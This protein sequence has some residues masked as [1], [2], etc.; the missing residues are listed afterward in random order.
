MASAYSILH[1]YDQPVYS[2]D[3]N[4]I[5]TA[6]SYKQQKFDQNVAKLQNAADQFAI[7]KVKRGVDQ[8]YINNRLNEVVRTTN[9]AMKGMDLSDDNFYTSLAANVGQVLDDNVKT[10]VLSTRQIQAEDAAM[11]A[12][13]K[14][15]KDGKYSQ[16]NHQYAIA[17]SDRA[18]YLTSDK[19][20]DGY[21]GGFNYIEYRDLSK[22]V[23][24]NL[25]KLA[26]G[27]KESFL[28]FV[29]QGSFRAMETYDKVDQ[30]KIKEAMSIVFDQKDMAQ[31]DVD[32]WATYGNVPLDVLKSEYE[33]YVRPKVDK[34]EEDLN[35]LQIR[36]KQDISPDEKAEIRKEIEDRQTYL[37]EVR[38]NNDFDSLLQANGRE[39]IEQRL[40]KGQF[41]E[42]IANT[43][44]Y[45]ERFVKRELDEV[46]AKNVELTEKQRQFDL[47][48]ELK[49][50]RLEFD[51]EQ[52]KLKAKKGTQQSG[53]VDDVD[54]GRSIVDYTGVFTEDEKENPIKI[55]E[56]QMEA[57]EKD[58]KALIRER[59]NGKNLTNKQFAEFSQLLDLAKVQ[60]GDTYTITLS[61]GTSL[62]FDPNKDYDRLSK[63]YKGFVE[64][65]PERKAYYEQTKNV[66]AR[67]QNDLVKLVR[68]KNSEVYN[69]I[70]TFY[71]KV[72]GDKKNG[73][74]LQ[75]VNGSGY[76]SYL[77]Q[78]EAKGEKLSE[79]DKMTLEAYTSLNLAT[80]DESAGD[81]AD[82]NRKALLA[83][84]RDR[85]L[86]GVDT[87]GLLPTLN[88][89]SPS[90]KFA[91]EVSYDFKSKSALDLY[92]KIL[93]SNGKSVVGSVYPKIPKG[94]V[95]QLI[96]KVDAF[97]DLQSKRNLTK[98]ELL[99]FKSTLQ[100]LRSTA[101]P[102][103]KVSANDLGDL[104]RIDSRFK[105][106]KGKI[107]SFGDY[108]GRLDS[109]WGTANSELEKVL[110]PSMD[111][112]RVGTISY[113]ED[114]PSYEGLRDFVATSSP[115]VNKNFSKPIF[116][117]RHPTDDTKVQIGITAKGGTGI[118]FKDFDRALVEQAVP[119]AKLASSEV[120]PYD[121]SKG[122]YAR[123]LNLG[124]NNLSNVE[125]QVAK[126]NKQLPFSTYSPDILLKAYNID[127]STQIGENYKQLIQ[128]YQT[129]K[130]KFQIEPIQGEYRQTMRT[131]RV[132]DD[133]DDNL[134][135]IGESLGKEILQE[136]EREYLR[137]VIEKNENLFQRYIESQVN[138]TY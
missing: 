72:V 30:D 34:I 26:E 84:V 62:S 17:K 124:S 81:L 76:F 79:A 109:L 127:P 64:D 58:M 69:S 6:L 126:A 91:A 137:D 59:F 38:S 85:V 40:Y 37:E 16:I 114:S 13:Q 131:T 10:A 50:D 90:K 35:T 41:F 55:F 28:K 15:D 93:G 89:V 129:G 56:D 46:H 21:R 19:L 133:E 32:S 132:S 74:K 96:K 12:L 138:T 5:N 116:M 36:L 120:A 8:E 54:P 14:N 87:K 2:P 104:G 111:V 113:N 80:G 125:K 98:D 82:A 44:G 123:K 102:K 110:K 88:D 86:R 134:L 43:Y 49:V 108:E 75:R 77:L 99:E 112:K 20:G 47:E 130:I 105:T 9:S 24:E 97:Y 22:K 66:V 51:K 52:A 57:S 18:R 33:S 115:E 48:Y 23:L 60:K 103:L 73:L 71:F 117:Q 11:E 135:Y 78:K 118:T 1:N 27:L 128:D 7:L 4:F 122:A 31:L 39:A 119:G 106:E 100:Q 29:D 94:E 63:F 83:Y 53:S 3:F 101:I 68:G 121:A 45:K 136:E 95:G 67:V 42:T 70:S 25:P 65:T 61:D 92:Q 107:V